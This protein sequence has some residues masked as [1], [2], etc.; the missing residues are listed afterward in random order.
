MCTVVVRVPERSGEP[1]RVLAIRDE[2]PAR[3]W[4]PPGAW[5]PE[6]YPDVRGVQD[7]RAGGAWLAVDERSRRLAVLLNRADDGSVAEDA[8]SRGWL[9][10]EGVSGRAPE[11]APDT[12]GFNL[13]QASPD[14]VHVSSWDGR[15]FA[16]SPLTPGTHMVAH[17]DVDDPRTARIT[18]WLPA[19]RDAPLPPG[20]AWYAPWLAI[21]AESATLDPTDDEALIRDHRHLGIPTLSLMLCAVT[22]GDE[23]TELASAALPA[24]GQWGPIHLA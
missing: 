15:R 14:A 18:R 22:V 12:R 7:V 8:P 19:F 10:L 5:W 23:G 9:S 3:P 13:V 6:R 11:S 16:S 2:D 4:R 17:D 24:P 20:P 1:V 21:V